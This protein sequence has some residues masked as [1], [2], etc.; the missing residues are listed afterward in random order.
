[1]LTL[2][3]CTSNNVMIM[4]RKLIRFYFTYSVLTNIILRVLLIPSSETEFVFHDTLIMFWHA[5]LGLD[6]HFVGTL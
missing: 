6:K 1:M 3:T 4:I 2:K 5:V